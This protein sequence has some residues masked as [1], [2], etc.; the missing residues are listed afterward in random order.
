MTSTIR[1]SAARSLVVLHPVFLLTGVLHAIGGPLLPSLVATFTLNDNQSGLLFLAYFSGTSLGALLCVGRYTRLMTIGFAVVVISCVALIF[2]PWPLQLFSFAAMGVGVGLPMSAVSLLVGRRFSGRSAPILVLLNFTW[3]V[4]ALIA[5][6]LAARVLMYHSFRTAYGWLA[7]V[8]AA[9]A[10]AC[11]LWLREE[12]ETPVMPNDPGAPSHRRM[13][14]ISALA[15]FLQVGIENTA[16]AWLSTYILRTTHSSAAF[17]ASLSALYWSGFLVSRA[18]SSLLL[19]R[20]ESAH[21]LRIAIPMAFAA[22]ILL[23]VAPSQSTGGVAM[24]LLGVACAPIYPLIVANSF[25]R[26]QLVSETRWVLA[27]AGV[28][29]SVLPWLTGWISA[30]SGSIRTGVLTLPAA[31]LL[32]LF[33]LP[34][35]SSQ[36]VFHRGLN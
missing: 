25:S 7:I 5:P 12:P 19:L 8:S 10:I 32:M 34:R 36:T 28:G 17:S 24:F 4:G 35:L 26:V 29:G 31:L 6:L 16:A 1:S 14:G 3:S 15:A 9:A 33:L 20:V 11:V 18:G 21:L 2:A 13:I 23:F 22:A 27:A 30:Q